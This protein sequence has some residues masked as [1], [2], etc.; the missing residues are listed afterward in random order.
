M[1]IRLKDNYFIFS[2]IEI[3]KLSKKKEHIIIPATLLKI[4][5]INK[6]LRTEILFSEVTGKVKKIDEWIEKKRISILT[7]FLM[8]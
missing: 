1:E 4:G 5:N 3:E 7:N 2:K 6:T 8:N